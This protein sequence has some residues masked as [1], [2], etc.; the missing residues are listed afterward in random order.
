MALAPRACAWRM[1]EDG[2][3]LRVKAQPRARRPG[4][5]G[6]VAGAD[7]PRLKVAVNEAPEDGRA[8]RAI[9][10]LLAKALAVVPSRVSVTQGTTSRE[11]T[12]LIGGDAAALAARMAEL[13]T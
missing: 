2:L 11:K 4:L 13:A 1:A 6:L 3:E 8:N 10:A 7:G 5:Q 12:V 9:C